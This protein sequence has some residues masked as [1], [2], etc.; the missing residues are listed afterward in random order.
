MKTAAIIAEYNPFHNGHALH[1]ERTR[2][3]A[4]ATHVVAIMS[5]DFVQRGSA[6]CADKRSRAIM[7]VR[8]GADL[9]V[10]LPLPWAM[11]GAETF[12]RG[13]VGLA[14]ALGCVDILSFGSECGDLEQIRRAAAMADS[15]EVNDALRKRLAQ[16]ENFAAAR[17]Q[18]LADVSPECA[19][20]M[21]GPN[22][23]L[24]VEYC[25]AIDALATGIQPFC[26]RRVGG[27][28]DDREHYEPGQPVSA[29][30]I[31]TL[32]RHK[33]TA[34]HT[35]HF[36]K[37]FM[38]PTSIDVLNELG[39]ESID[40][41]ISKI[42][43]TLIYELRRMSPEQIAALPDVSEG[44]EHRI[45]ECAAN[46]SG[47]DAGFVRLSDEIKCKRY[48]HARVRRILFSAVLGLTAGDSAGTPPYIRVL[49]MNRRGQ[50][51]LAASAVARGE[52]GLPVI[53]RYAQTASLDE[54]G[55]RVFELCANAADVYGLMLDRI[56]PAGADR[57][58]QL[59]VE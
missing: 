49:A 29:S 41:D 58:Y 35:S 46:I 7:A 17:A 5:G 21:S 16:G 56:R 27:G 24:G 59:P 55:R 48:T 45:A 43:R 15:P 53:T 23:L 52:K 25:R 31:R 19:G 13:G 39:E 54:R 36:L 28:H 30:Y 11:A 57:A 42:D 51:I 34:R 44:L 50:E 12:A 9:V 40:P 4:G 22:D 26:I 10:E 14:A 47:T 18:A 32:L 20:I 6:A 8:G 33:V 1:I 38:P 37:E 3:Q 2:Q